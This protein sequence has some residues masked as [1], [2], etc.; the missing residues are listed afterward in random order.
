MWIDSKQQMVADLDQYVGGDGTLYPGNFPKAE[1]PGLTLVSENRPPLGDFQTYGKPV[2]SVSGG[3]AL[4]TYPVLTAP[5]DKIIANLTAAVQRH[6]DATARA[7]NY[8][9]IL[10]ACSYATDTNP[11][12]MAEG[13]AAVNWRG[14][15]WVTCYQIMG[16]VQA[17]TRSIPTEAE[18]IALLPVMVWP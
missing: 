6:L 13:Q 15:V 1:I 10:S 9:G 18:L 8:D 4:A 16:E 17:G 7:R 12:F 3:V 11:P 2:V 5:Q 14:A